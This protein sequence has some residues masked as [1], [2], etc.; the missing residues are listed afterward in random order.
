MFSATAPRCRRSKPVRTASAS[1]TRPSVMPAAPDDDRGHRPDVVAQREGRDDCGRRDEVRHR[2]QHE[3]DPEQRGDLEHAGGAYRFAG[4][5]NIG[6]P[7][8][9]TSV[10][11]TQIILEGMT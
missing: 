3:D 1:A 6:T 5:G 11:C 8:R 2:A 4:I 7:R 10:S 9:V